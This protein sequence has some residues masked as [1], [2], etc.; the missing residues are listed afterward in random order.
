MTINNPFAQSPDWR[1]NPDQMC[2]GHADEAAHLVFKA[3]LDEHDRLMAMVI[4]MRKIS[5]AES[6]LPELEAAGI[7]VRKETAL[8]GWIER[9]SETD[10]SNAQTQAQGLIRAK[11]CRAISEEV[12]RLYLKVAAHFQAEIDSLQAFEVGVFSNH[13]TP[14]VDTT[15]VVTLRG[16]INLAKFRADEAINEE[17]MNRGGAYNRSELT[18]WLPANLP[19]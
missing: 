15:I 11:F 14:P 17:Y 1:V 2:D 6:L 9:L 7:C 16:L 10:L 5:K 13:R 8:K 12:R 19:L 4:E 18:R 3:A